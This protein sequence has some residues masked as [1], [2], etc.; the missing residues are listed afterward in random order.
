MNTSQAI[1]ETRAG[2]V[3]QW[4]RNVQ[5]LAGHARLTSRKK[6]DWRNALAGLVAIVLLLGGLAAS[7][8]AEPLGDQLGAG[9]D[10]NVQADAKIFLRLTSSSPELAA[11]MP[12]AR[13]TVSVDLSTDEI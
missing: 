8:A 5:R 11:C 2:G 9:K 4:S 13:L 7:A 3:R 6:L 12:Y 10:S 1:D